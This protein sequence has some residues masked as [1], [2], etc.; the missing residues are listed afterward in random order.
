MRERDRER[1]RGRESERAEDID[2]VGEWVGERET[3]L[4]EN[5]NA[6]PGTTQPGE[7]AKSVRLA[8][9]DDTS[10]TGTD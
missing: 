10:H 4:F 6:G 5:W 7:S 1:E 2:G 9:P 3:H 8:T